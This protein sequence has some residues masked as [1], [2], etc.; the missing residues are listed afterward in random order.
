M[1]TFHLGDILSVTTERLCSPRGIDALYDLLSY[2]TG[3]NLMTHQLPRAND[4]CKPA[5]IEQMPGL[6]A[7]QMP[8]SLEG[9]AAVMAWLDEQ[10]QLYGEEYEVEP[11]AA[12]QR[13]YV[14]PLAEQRQ[15]MAPDAQIIVVDTGTGEVSDG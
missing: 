2:M 6:A 3:E 13:E 7:V 1:K 5:L 4:D 8:E 12:G 14:D 15:M 9:P 11:L 10:V